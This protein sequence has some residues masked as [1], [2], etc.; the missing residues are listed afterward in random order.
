MK[1]IT[2]ES[3]VKALDWSYDKSV[4]G[5]LPGSKDVDQLA[6]EYL[7][8]YS[9]PEVAITK[10]I[11]WQ[12]GKTAT[13]GFITGFGGLV[14]MPFTL[15]ADITS[16][17]YVQLRMIAV[18]SKIRGYNP[19]DDEIRSLAYICLTGSSTADFLK[20]S[21]IVVA[22]KLGT[23]MIK[24]IPGRVLVKI[25]QAVG[26]RL[27]TKFGEKGVLNLGKAV[28]VLGAIVGCGVDFAS[29]NV[30]AKATK[31]NFPF[32]TRNTSAF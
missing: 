21:G 11:R 5:G 29:T 17:I 31:K 22:E 4:N 8:K 19:H 25:N 16:V 32:R 18:I 28:P 27:I 9:E 24:K 30:I 3:M 7:N 14:T 23:N 10:F 20:K 13:S 1:G 15:P 26:F 2:Q 12:K 6:T